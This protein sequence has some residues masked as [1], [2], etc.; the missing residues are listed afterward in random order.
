VTTEDVPLEELAIGDQTQARARLNSA[1]VEEYA[2]AM[3]EG[4]KFPPVVL[5]TQGDE[6]Y[7]VADGFHRI[8]AA[9]QLRE[10]LARLDSAMP[11]GQPLMPGLQNGMQAHVGGNERDKHK[12]AARADK[13][14]PGVP[15]PSVDDGR[16]LRQRSR[17]AW[18]GA[19]LQEPRD[20]VEQQ[21]SDEQP[22]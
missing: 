13:G 11:D 10:Q 18:G 3:S 1:I 16:D 2:E 17:E 9:R 21:R 14:G 20:E 7:W 4:A 19:P 8:K 5:F 6:P 22:A 15:N 12:I